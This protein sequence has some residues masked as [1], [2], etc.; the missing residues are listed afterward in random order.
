MVF[1][2]PSAFQSF[3]CKAYADCLK[4][5]PFLPHR[6][7][8]VRYFGTD[9]GEDPAPFNACW[10]VPERPFRRALIFINIDICQNGPLS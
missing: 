2:R 9:G 3:D 7:S 5:C 1:I 4:G 6:P 10:V 8:L